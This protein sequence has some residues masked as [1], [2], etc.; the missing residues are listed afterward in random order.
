MQNN[1]SVG[2]TLEGGQD[3]EVILEFLLPL[4]YKLLGEGIPVLVLRQGRDDQPNELLFFLQ[5]CV[6]FL[7]LIHPSLDG[8]D[9]S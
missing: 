5:D 7:E 4:L 8:V 9:R 1:F 6:Q 3:G 2:V